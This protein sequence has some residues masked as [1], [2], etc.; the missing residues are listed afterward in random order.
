MKK[1][2]GIILLLVILVLTTTTLGFAEENFIK[3]YLTKIKVSLDGMR[4]LDEIIVI[5]GTSY[6]PVRKLSNMF[7]VDVN[8]NSYTNEIELINNKPHT[9]KPRLTYSDISYIADVKYVYDN[10]TVYEGQ[11]RNGL[12]HGEGNKITFPDGTT[13]RGSFIDGVIQGEG[14]Y[15]AINGDTYQGLFSNNKYKGYGKYTYVNGDVIEG[16]FDGNS[17]VADSVIYVKIKAT[18]ETKYMKGKDWN[19]EI[20]G[21]NTYSFNFD[22]TRF[23]GTADIVFRDGT[24]YK[25]SISNNTF[26]GQGEITYIDGSKY[27]GN[28]VSDQ[29]T[30]RGTFTYANNTKYDGYFL[31]NQY[32][33]EGKFYYANGDMYDGTWK[34]NKRHGYGKYTFANDNYFKGNWVNGNK[35]TLD[36]TDDKDYKGYGEYVL[37][38]NNNPNLDG[39]RVYY[40]QKWD[41]GKLIKEIKNR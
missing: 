13:Y 40:K 29:K 34:A 25:G 1:R 18:N 41:N 24:H 11:I 22:K 33:G 35:H 4:V 10:G 31:N 38:G 3:A 20:M 9:V 8:W 17:L 39:K 19:R 14:Q 36:Q 27:K 16:E 2:L 12:Y 6:L 15:T 30:G 5:N 37:D 32:D 26:N 21:V 23:N 28:W 7:G